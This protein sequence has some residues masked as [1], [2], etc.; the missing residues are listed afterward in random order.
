MKFKVLLVFKVAI[1]FVEVKYQI[2]YFVNEVAAPMTIC[3]LRE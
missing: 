2:D 3:Y 1:V